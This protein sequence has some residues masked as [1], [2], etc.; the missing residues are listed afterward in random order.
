[1]YATL[2]I[3][4]SQKGTVDVPREIN[5]PVFI[6]RYSYSNLRTNFGLRLFKYSLGILDLLSV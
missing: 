3:V 5:A 6:S 2:I 4:H 1:M